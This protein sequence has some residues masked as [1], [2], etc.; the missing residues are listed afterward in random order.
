MSG[1]SKV[2]GHVNVML[3]KVI[4]LLRTQY[5]DKPCPMGD[6]AIW[7]ALD[8]VSSITYGKDLGMLD[9]SGKRG[10]LDAFAYS[11]VY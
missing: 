2:E 10:M 9:G 3:G 6:V 11:L 4:D 1:L 5:T 8:A 7:F